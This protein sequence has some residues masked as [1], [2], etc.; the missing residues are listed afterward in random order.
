M[1]MSDKEFERLLV[2]YHKLR[3]TVMWHLIFVLVCIVTA[4]VLRR[5][6][7]YPP[8]LS[9]VVFAVP[10]VLFSTDFIR[11]IAC[12]AKLSRYRAHHASH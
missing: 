1:R 8:M 4:V 12:R 2:S 5:A 11:L 10:A 9:W 3:R 7:N 6:L